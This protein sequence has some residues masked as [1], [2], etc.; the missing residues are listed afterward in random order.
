M[1]DGFVP[2]PRRG[3]VFEQAQRVGPA[4]TTPAGRMRLDE[5]ARWLQD[6]AYAD[7]VDA[8]VAEA[9]YWVVRKTR[10]RVDRWPGFGESLRLRTFCSGL[11]PLLAER[12]T[13]VA[14][15]DGAAVE[16]VSLWVNVDPETRLPARLPE[17]FL[18]GYA[19]A[20]GERRV[21]GRL[22]HPDPPAGATER[23]WRFRAADLDVAGHVNNAVYWAVVDER[24][25]SALDAALEAEIEHRE[26]ALAGDV[27]VLEDGERLWVTSPAGAVH[28]SARLALES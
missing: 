16:I 17:R 28:A 13:S 23:P 12:R 26:P 1:A 11:A 21:R 10:L 2:V 14:G 8:G 25:E 4:D 7:I 3:R 24:L 20:A 27:A 22:R 19:E 6:L 5:L 18:A 9:T 15:D